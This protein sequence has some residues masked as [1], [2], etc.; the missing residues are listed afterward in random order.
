MEKRRWKIIPVNT[1]VGEPQDAAEQSSR[2]RA[3]FTGW[4]IVV[5]RGREGDKRYFYGLGGHHTQGWLPSQEKES[6]SRGTGL[7]LPTAGGIPSEGRRII[8]AGAQLRSAS[9]LNSYTIELH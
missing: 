6:S 5:S 4:E 2:T 3:R 7:N 9:R 8:L 1:S